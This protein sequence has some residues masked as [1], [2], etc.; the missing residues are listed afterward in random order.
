MAAR[1]SI[2]PVER[3]ESHIFLIRG[4]KVMLSTHLADLYEVEPRALVQ[5][6]M[7][8]RERF[9]MTSCFS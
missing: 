6:V 9:L 7:R 5:A 2:V 3:I 4:K 8:N 1:K